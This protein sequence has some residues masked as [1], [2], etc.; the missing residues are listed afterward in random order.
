MKLDV[1][2]DELLPHPVQAVWSEITSA[3]AISDW[4]MM[5]TTDFEPAVGCRF[6][7]KTDRLSTTG[8][9]EAEV[10][11]IDAPR[12]MVWSWSV[13]DGNPPSTV[14]FDLVED[15]RG[16]RLRLRH[17]GEFDEQVVE[18]LR[19]GWPGRIE[20]IDEKIRRAVGNA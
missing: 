1:E 18:L 7:L 14:S 19:S 9:I 10:L 6:R 20:A 13:S 4:L 17:V 2:Y 3:A 5:A 15:A 16:T 12:R 8:W 11:E